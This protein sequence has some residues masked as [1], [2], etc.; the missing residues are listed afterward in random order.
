[1][2][3]E[4]LA[5]TIRRCE[6]LST[7][8]QARVLE[9]YY[10]SFPPEERSNLA[11]VLADIAGN[12]EIVYLAEAGERVVGF[13]TLMPLA[14]SGIVTGEYLAVDPTLRNQRLGGDILAY[15]CDDL[16]QRGGRGLLFEIE[17]LDEGTPEERAL[18][19]RRLDFYQ[20]R[21]GRIV[22]PAAI[23]HT[24]I[25]G[26]DRS[27]PMELVWLPFDPAGPDLVA[28][29]LRAAVASLY[30]DSLRCPADDPRLRSILRALP[31]PPPGQRLAA[32]ARRALRRVRRLWSR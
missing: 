11:A 23:Y 6:T 3:D 27:M 25:F 30:T 7:A 8:Q 28:A 9:I 12:G 22:V 32:L 14:V 4:P 31:Q 26:S 24:P 13:A 18:R 5:I 21:G 16:A 1:M 19:Q 15:A 20:R 17:A 10:A 29:E 2:S